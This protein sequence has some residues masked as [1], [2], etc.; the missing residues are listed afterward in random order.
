MSNEQIEVVHGSGNIFADLGL[1][2][3]DEELAKAETARAIR[4]IVKS[5][6]LTQARAAEIMG[7]S[8]PN[9]SMI[10]GGKLAQFS[11]ERLLKNLRMLGVNIS[12]AFSAAP[13]GQATGSLT[14]RG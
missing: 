2:A 6:K 11:L 8:Q 14:I 4:R 1:P 5:R 13:E 10:L 3:A 12:V 9:V 7:E